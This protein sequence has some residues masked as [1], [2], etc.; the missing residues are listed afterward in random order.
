[1]EKEND[2]NIADVINRVK[3]LENGLEK[4]FADQKNEIKAMT[5]MIGSLSQ[6]ASV[7]KDG[8]EGNGFEAN[9]QEFLVLGQR[10]EKLR[11]DVV[12]QERAMS[13]KRKRIDSEDGGST[14]SIPERSNVSNANINSWAGV[15]SKNTIKNQNKPNGSWKNRQNILHGTSKENDCYAFSADISLAVYGLAKD[16][17]AEK[18]KEYLE[19]KN[20]PVLGCELLTKFVKEA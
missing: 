13:P 9:N 17:T 16:A 1:M 19:A 14:Y 10:V 12:R 18:L 7:Q 11:R 6:G 8:K 20:L 5:E 4:A 3:L 2:V 15:A